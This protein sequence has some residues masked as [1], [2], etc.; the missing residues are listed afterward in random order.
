MFHQKTVGI[1]M[2]SWFKEVKLEEISPGF[3][4]VDLGERSSSIM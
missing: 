3:K 4:W 1:G 2:M